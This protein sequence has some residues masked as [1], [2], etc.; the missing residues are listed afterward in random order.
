M[1]CKSFIIVSLSVNKEHGVLFVCNN[2]KSSLPTSHWEIHSWPYKMYYIYYSFKLHSQRFIT[3]N[4]ASVAQP[5]TLQH[6]N[7][8]HTAN[9][10]NETHSG[11]VK[12]LIHLFD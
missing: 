12:Q 3:L 6:Y 2:T 11:L 1:S 5:Q 4:L 10:K 9:R 7:K 8:R